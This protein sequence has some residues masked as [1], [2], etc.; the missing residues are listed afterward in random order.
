MIAVTGGTGRIG[1]RVVELLAEAG[2]DDV[3]ALSS[4]TAP[5]DDPAALRAAFDGARTLVFVSSDGEA[6]RV[7]NHHRNV[8]AAAREVGHI[9]ALSGLDVAMDSP[10]CY[11]YTNGDTERLL[12]AG[13]RPYSIARAGLFTE[14]FLGLVRQVAVD[15]TVALPAGDA[16]VSLVAREDVARGLAALAL[17][18]PLHGHRDVT[19]P[20]SRPVA[21]IVESAGYAYEECSP[22]QLIATLARLGEEPWWIYAYTSMFASISQGRWA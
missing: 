17:G 10:F 6:A 2:R 18:E 13:D 9:V 3:V 4:R 1:G 12:R 22:A 20:D 21:E 16:R 8:L 19:G 11:A 7:V 5:Y 14:F 15:G